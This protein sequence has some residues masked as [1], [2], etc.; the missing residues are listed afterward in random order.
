M[1]NLCE[2]PLRLSLEISVLFSIRDERTE[3][4]DTTGVGGQG[5]KR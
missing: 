1:T 3:L 2:K 4:T 5:K